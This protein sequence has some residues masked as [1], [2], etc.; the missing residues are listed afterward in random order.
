[1][2]LCAVCRVSAAPDPD[3]DAGEHVGEEPARGITGLEIV[4]AVVALSALAIAQPLL[5]LIGRNP[6]FLTAHQMGR[7]DTLALGIGLPVLLPLAAGLLL[8]ATGLVHRG[9]RNALATIA[10]ALLGAVFALVVLRLSGLAG[11]IP[12]VA[13][14]VVAAA[15]G[16][17][18]AAL[19]R[20]SAVTRR[21]LA[22]AAIAAPVTAVMFVGMSAARGVVFPTTPEAA[23]P[24]LGPDSPPIVFIVFDEL[25]LVSLL[26]PGRTI[27]AETYPS[28]AKLA[29]DGT[30][31]RNGTSVHGFS[32]DAVPAILT[33]RYTKFDAL[34]VVDDHPRNLFTMLSGTYDLRS[35]EVLTQLCPPARCRSGVGSA[36]DY[37]TTVRDLGVVAAHLV[38]PP[39]MTRGLPSL[40]EGFADFRAAVE[41]Q[42]KHDAF[43]ER[44]EEQRGDDVVAGFER[45]VRSIAPADKP[46]LYFDHVLMPHRPWRYLPNGQVYNGALIREKVWPSAWSAKQGYQRHLLQ[47]GRTDRLLGRL[48]KRLEKTGMYDDALIVVVADHGIS[49]Q[50]GGRL[51]SLSDRNF[52]EI[53][54]VPMIV[55]APRQV[56]GAISDRPVETVDLVPSILDLLGVQPPA[57]LDGWSVVDEAT[58]IRKNKRFFPGGRERLFPASG[59][60]IDPF[61]DRKLRLFGSRNRP[62]SPFRIAPPGTRRL[63]GEPVPT[64]GPLPGASVSIRDG[65]AYADVDVDADALP[66]LVAGVVRLETPGQP[67]PVLAIGVNGVIAAITVAGPDGGDGPTFSALVPPRTLRDGANDITVLAVDDG[68]MTPLATA[69]DG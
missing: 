36:T 52:G 33:G 24:D 41:E 57:D 32:P 28:F 59:R 51:R 30:W 61:L 43:L 3:A 37:G 66:V 11:R 69:P 20:R 31:F 21:L 56:D 14:L 5:D 6:S 39:S 10:V 44:F 47:L 48:I 42:G 17:G 60:E 4:L 64:G 46:T 67:P 40:D 18:A 54:A 19:W 2:P 13:A 58:P 55:K 45:F 26:G 23:L 16:A 22:V 29:A 15:I 68:V 63:L 8:V 38:L 35:V 53:A 50:P 65:E 1:M 7:W 9:A 12:G 49:F 62:F 27:D 34:P 25:P